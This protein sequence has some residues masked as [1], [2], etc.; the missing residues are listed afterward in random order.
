M[1]GAAQN[2]IYWSNVRAYRVFL[3]TDLI[4]RFPE[5]ESQIAQWIKEGRIEYREKNHAGVE[6]APGSLQRLL[7]GGANTGKFIMRLPSAKT[8]SSEQPAWLPRGGDES[9]SSQNEPSD[10]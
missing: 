9:S 3:F 2:V 8:L 7:C 6:R 1:S 4:Q 10:L 5:G